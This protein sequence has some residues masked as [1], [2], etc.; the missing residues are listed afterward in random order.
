MAENNIG[1]KSVKEQLENKKFIVPNY[2]R[3]YK[4]REK[5]V[6]YL[7]ED[8]A[9]IDDEDYKDYCLQPIVV[10]RRDS[11][12]CEYILI[13]GQ[14]RLTTI[15]LIINW[16]RNYLKNLNI[17]WNFKIEYE[18]RGE[19]NE[20]L[21][22]IY[23]NGV[24]D[25]KG[26]CDTYYF[27]NALQMIESK[28]D[29]LESFVKNLVK[30]V[31]IIWY[32]IDRID[33]PAHFERLN[34]A[35]IS[36]TNAELVKALVL[37]N[38]GNDIRA[39]MACEWD[40]M[41]YSL[42]NDRFFSFITTKKSIYNN[43]YNRIELLLDLYANANNIKKEKDEFYT[44]NY[45]AKRVRDNV[46]IEEIWQ[47][48][49]NI[50]NRLACWYDDSFLY[51]MIGYLVEYKGD[52]ELLNIWENSR[53]KSIN[54]F[55]E[56]IRME[57]VKIIPNN[58]KL[59]K[60]V[61]KDAQTKNILLLFNILSLLSISNDNNEYKYFFNEKFHFE[62]YKKDNW[63]KEH[64]HATAS[65]AMQSKVEWVNWMKDLDMELVN[66]KLDDDNGKKAEYMEWLKKAGK[67]KQEDYKSIREDKCDE[68]KLLTKEYFT[69]M[70]QDIIEAIEGKEDEIDFRQNSI[71]NIVLLDYHTNRSG[72]YKVAPFSTKRRIIMERVKNGQ[73]VP[74]GTQNV[75]MKVYTPNPGHFYKWEKIEGYNGN[76][77]SD[78]DNYLEAIIE[79]LNRIK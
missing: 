69:K 46:D 44:F 8:I 65:Q 1:L 38:V 28:R 66:D 70:Y 21:N 19:S 37:T 42:Q 61:Y 53:G 49:Q 75:F 55:K 54:E 25:K 26:T 67:I 45:I 7:I 47:E 63:D 29:L 6:E 23:S 79:T 18:T 32:E 2:Q 62:L 76:R 60:M 14:Q 9:E 35:K 36:L 78:R 27:S 73:F 20:Y 71:G 22:E 41:E 12:E 4:W 24:S 74:L 72:E 43:D 10:A 50:Y 64:V 56:S 59:E 58:E 11:D 52:S 57:I 15:W 68:F 77:K 34:S 33:G 31:K 48:I 30:N 5:D 3:G 17:Q 40:E 16:A 13:D 39:R 51:N